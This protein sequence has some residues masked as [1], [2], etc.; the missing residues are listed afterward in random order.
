MTSLS[1]AASLT[2]LEAMASRVPVVVT[3][4]GGNP[5]MV[6]DGQD[7]FLVPRQDVQAAA[8]SIATLLDSQDE[9]ESMGRAARTRVE[10]R[11]DLQRTVDRHLAVYDRVSGR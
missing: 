10:Q 11:Y 8:S 7:G 5:E 9:A 3:D 1:E 2:V 6:R 4:V